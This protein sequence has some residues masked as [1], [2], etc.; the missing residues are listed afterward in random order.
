MNI[1][2]DVNLDEISFSKDGRS[3]ELYFIDMHEGK[4]VGILNCLSVYSFK[5]QNCF[6]DDDSLAA[7]IGEV[8]Y[9][10]IKSKELLK[11]LNYNFHDSEQLVENEPLLINIE[12]GELVLEIICRAAEFNNKDIYRDTQCAEINR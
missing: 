9:E 5:Y 3:V 2:R 11:N 12:G 4:R 7:Y 6:E 8:N 10:K 1:L